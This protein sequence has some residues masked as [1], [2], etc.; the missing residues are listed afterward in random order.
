[1]RE[2]IEMAIDIIGIICIIGLICYVWKP[3][4]KQQYEY[5]SVKEIE[6]D[7]NLVVFYKKEKVKK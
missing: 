5:K 2:V 7:H 4:H 6:D 1:M 3:N